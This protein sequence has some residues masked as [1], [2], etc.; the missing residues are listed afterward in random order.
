MATTAVT[1]QGMKELKAYLAYFP[2]EADRELRREIKSTAERIKHMYRREL[3]KHTDTGEL[4]R[5]IN[6]ETTD[7]FKSVR[8]GSDVMQAVFIE[9]G[10][11]AHDIEPKKAQALMF[12]WPKIGMDMAAKKVRHPGTKADP[13]LLRT[14]IAV[15]E[16]NSKFFERVK[17][18]FGA[19]K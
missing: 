10:T 3:R 13:A 5:S 19:I 12:F 7:A 14:W 2:K 6:V 16:P 17:K 15:M 1:I 11:R 4:D 18:R 9:Y 8:V